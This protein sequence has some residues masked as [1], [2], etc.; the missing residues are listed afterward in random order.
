MATAGNGS[1]RDGRL[2]AQ[3]KTR[4]DVSDGVKLRGVD[5]R[6][7]ADIEKYYGEDHGVYNRSD[8]R[9]LVEFN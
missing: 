4:Q 6:V 1:R 3:K 5:E 9:T 2:L 8:P 7:G